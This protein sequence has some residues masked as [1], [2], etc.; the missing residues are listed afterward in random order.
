MD[1]R[2][3]YQRKRNIEW[4]RIQ[5]GVQ[6][7]TERAKLAAILLVIV[8]VLSVI[9]WVW[10]NAIRQALEPLKMLVRALGF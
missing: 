3:Q 4:V 1:D 9:D 5:P 10:P 6:L 7:L 2:E 8:F